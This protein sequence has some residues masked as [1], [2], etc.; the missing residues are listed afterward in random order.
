MKRRW[1][2]KLIQFV[3]LIVP[4]RLR[5]DWRQEWEAELQWRAQQL[6]A[7]DKLDSKNKLELMWHS[8]GAFLDALWLQP[9][10]WED[11]MWQDLRYGARTLWK[12]PGFTLIAVLTLMLGI[13]ATTAIFSVVNAVLLKPLPYDEAERLVLLME[14][15]ETFGEESVAYLNFVD[16]R[17]QQSVFESL[18][19]Y[20]GGSYTLTGRGEAMQLNGAQ[21]T[22]EVL[23]ALRIKP[24]LGRLF[25][26][27][28]DKLGAT[29]VVVLSHG[30][31]QE[32]FG[33]DPNILNRTVTLSDRSYTVI[34]VLPPDFF[35]PRRFDL[36]LPLGPLT[37]KEGYQKRY[38]HPG[39]RG[40]ARLKPGVTM[41]QAQAEM[42][43]IAARLAT[44]YPD[45]NKGNSVIVRPLKEDIVGNVERALW[46]TL[47]AVGCVL[48][49]ACANVANLLLARAAAR[50][51]EL[52][53]RVALGASRLRIARQLLTESVLLALL[54]GVP[55][56]LLAHGA[57]VLLLQL[58][59]DVL[60]RTGEIHLDKFVLAFALVVTTLTGL[61]FG[62][63]PAWQ[64]G[65]TQAQ[66]ALKDAGRSIAGSKARFRHA[67]VVA[68]V[69]VTLVL[70][71]GAGLLLRSFNQLLRT[72][73][74]FQYENLLT[75]AVDLPEQ[76][77]APIEPQMAFFQKLEQRLRTLPGVTHVG[78]SSGLPLGNNGW[79]SNFVI[80]GRPIPPAN[81]LPSMEMTLVS[82]GYFEAMKI[83]LR[84]GRW[85][86]ER[87]NRDHLRGRDLSKLEPIP[88]LVAGLNCIVID[89]EFARRHWPNESAIGK[90]VRF[91]AV[92]EAPLLT[93]LGVVGRV[94]MDGLRA[95]SN[96]VQAYVPYQQ[97]SVPDVR[98]LV[99][100]ATDPQ[101]VLTAV[102]AAVQQLDPQLPLHT[103]KTMAQLR[104]ET[105][106]PD[107]LNL[108]LLGSF[109]AL[110]LALALIGL[111]G[112][113]S[114][115][116]TQRTSELG[117]RMALGAQ[118]TDVLRLVLG[119]GMKLTLLGI[120]IG[121]VAAVF[122]TRL[123]H[124]LLFN[125]S[126][127]DPLTYSAIAVLLSVVAVLACWLPAR[128][129]A[130]VDPMIA[131]RHE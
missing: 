67:L 111:Y 83:P 45:S 105:V 21:A 55:G 82:P 23:T 34:G 43:T 114:Y 88:R 59:P 9:K 127:T 2:L 106:A 35:F 57:L 47:A 79:S 27:D 92:P 61:L 80:E 49:I 62:L 31:W 28:D 120:G 53:V 71:V 41:A 29:P 129:A 6:A 54:G 104:A 11:E 69:A 119:Q 17:A 24:A 125:V 74:G 124:S 30:L 117:I 13:G 5:A 113:I 118:T 64:A 1:H 32:R 8:A 50:Q 122:L 97:G 102:R 95:E 81:E 48:L 63:V 10:R 42:Q 25:T 96:R 44:A 16:W 99:R 109:A 19:V 15:A 36:W 123:M 93:V 115:T 94:K 85:F 70:L 66:Q 103:V 126:A 12:Q 56:L 37:D 110:A 73:P 40:L 39:L 108:T 86:D 18:G 51:R 121:I 116:V 7:W 22:A 75:F 90:R 4:R 14:H 131:L 100:T 77:Y 78:Y 46:V 101:A 3:S 52:A 89:E 76:R 72:E 60:P 107:R 130:K 98:V 128:R 26:S 91:G 38:N 58:S 65:H 112:V 87:D 68:E 20:N 84:A 33:G